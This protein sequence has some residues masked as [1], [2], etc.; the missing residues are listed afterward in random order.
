[1]MKPKLAD[2]TI[3]KVYRTLYRT[4]LE[5]ILALCRLLSPVIGS[6]RCLS[7]AFKENFGINGMEY[8]QSDSSQ[9]EEWMES[10][11]RLDT[12]SVELRCR[13]S[14]C[15]SRHFIIKRHLAIDLWKING[16]QA[17]IKA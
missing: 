10:V 12:K 14:K 4:R 6:L 9:G 7:N 5:G 3:V 16:R 11:K 17:G 15:V 13:I 1:M 2:G 8:V